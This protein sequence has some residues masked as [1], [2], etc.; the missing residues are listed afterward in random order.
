MTAESYL[1][2][3]PIGTIAIG[4]AF[5]IILFFKDR[6]KALKDRQD[7]AVKEVAKHLQ[8]IRS[9]AAWTPFRD[10]FAVANMVTSGEVFGAFDLVQCRKCKQANP[11]HSKY[12]K[13][14]GRSIEP[15][16][17]PN[18]YVYEPGRI[19]GRGSDAK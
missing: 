3:I 18:S 2:L 19:I 17:R 4:T 5:G 16:S 13:R 14:C 12:C 9:A 15:P 8:E 7:E 6:A 1:S 10:R 11:V